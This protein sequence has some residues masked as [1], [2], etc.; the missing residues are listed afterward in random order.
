M[1]KEVQDKKQRKAIVADVVTREYTI[2]LN[3]MVHGRYSNE[4]TPLIS[5]CLALVFFLV[6]VLFLMTFL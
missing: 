3:K 2:H 4:R 5:P 1:A 6:L